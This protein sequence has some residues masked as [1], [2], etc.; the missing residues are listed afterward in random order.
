[1]EELVID[2]E[3]IDKKDKLKQEEIIKSLEK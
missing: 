1:M 3:Y 2:I